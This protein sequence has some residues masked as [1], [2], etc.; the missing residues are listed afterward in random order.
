MNASTL[1][2]FH[3]ADVLHALLAGLLLFQQLALAADVAAV[4]L[5][6]VL[7]LRLHRLARQ[8]ARPPMA[9][10]MGTSRTHLAN[11]LAEFLRQH[12]SAIVR[13]RLYCTMN[14]SASMGFARK[15]YLQ[16]PASRASGRR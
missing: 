12:A 7:A 3:V 4:A 14:D 1:L 13:R 16:L 10:W 8:R 15:Q 11:D 5:T 6:N 2:N 9:A